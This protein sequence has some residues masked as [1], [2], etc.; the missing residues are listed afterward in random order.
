MINIS[1]IDNIYLAPGYTDLRRSIDGC[2]AIVK[3]NM[4]LDPVSTNIF[5]FCNKKKKTIKILQWDNTGFW[6]HTKK[7]IGENRF[8]WPKNNEEASSIII[9]KTQLQWLLS[10]MDINQKHVNKPVMPIITDK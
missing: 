7:L 5:I 3:Y 9:D 1:K 10:G 4:Y 8:R 6:L 2:S